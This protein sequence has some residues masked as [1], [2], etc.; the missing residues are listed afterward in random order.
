MSSGWIK[1]HRSMRDWGWYHKS[2]MVH[3]WL[4]LLLRANHKQR[5]F[6][7]EVVNRGQ[8]VCGRKQLAK[9]TGITEQ[10][11]RTCLTRLK[12]TNEITIKS[13]KRFSVVTINNYHTYQVKEDETNQEDNQ[14]FP[15]QLT[16][17]QPTG[18]HKQEGK[19]GRKEEKRKVFIKPTVE[20]VTAYGKEIDFPLDG[21]GFMD[22]YESKGWVVGKS[23]MKDWKATVRNWKRMDRKRKKD[24]PTPPEPPRFN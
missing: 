8:L 12:S 17:D 11:I 3:L 24:K 23:K 14:L 16:N 6:E 5:V 21:G 10:T 18:N 2:E 19:K 7:G 15:Q 22:Y 9:E 1:L 20:E 13:T 4:H